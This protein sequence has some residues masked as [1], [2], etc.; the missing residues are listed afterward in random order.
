MSDA[1]EDPYSRIFSSL[2]HP[3]RR[4]LLRS[5]KEQPSKRFSKLQS[6]LGNDSPTLSYH[7]DPLTGL[8]ERRGDG[9]SLTDLGTAALNLMGELRRRGRQILPL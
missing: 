3:T 7:L 2:K 9:Y 6:D 5:L 4:L 8:V 1:E